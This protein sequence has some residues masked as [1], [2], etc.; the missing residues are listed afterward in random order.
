M[1]E[2]CVLSLLWR[3]GPGAQHL[4]ST[5]KEVLAASE[6]LIFPRRNLL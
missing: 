2:G 6:L 1:G 5:G 4:R 3:E